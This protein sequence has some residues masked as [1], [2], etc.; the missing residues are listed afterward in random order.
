MLAIL[1]VLGV[2]NGLVLLPVLLSYFGPYPEVK[3][4]KMQMQENLNQPGLVTFFKIKKPNYRQLSVLNTQVS[5]VDGRS[6]LPTP[7][8]E[9]PPHVVHFSV[10]PHHTTA[11]TTTSG[12]VSDSSDSEY[13]SNTTASGISQELQ[14]S[15]LHSHRGQA[16]ADEQQYHLQISRGRARTEEMRRGASGHR[17]SA[18]QP[19]PPAYTVSSVRE[20]CHIVSPA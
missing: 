16:R 13:S 14:N 1:T 18:R 10:R 11:A 20:I 3:S 5:P 12:A 15:N 6:R 4:Y 2:L 7:S 19:D 17:R 8:P 9:A